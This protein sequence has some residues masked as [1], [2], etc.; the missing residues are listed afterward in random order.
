MSRSERIFIEVLVTTIMRGGEDIMRRFNNTCF[1]LRSD[2]N[3]TMT[4]IVM[5]V[6]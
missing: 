5:Y 3:H 1:F 2:G 6:M 4:V